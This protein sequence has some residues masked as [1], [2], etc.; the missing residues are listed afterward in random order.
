MSVNNENEEEEETF[1]IS[2]ELLGGDCSGDSYSIIV[3]KP[4]DSLLLKLFSLME[5]IRT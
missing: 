5:S 4:F 3:R 1:F 2:V